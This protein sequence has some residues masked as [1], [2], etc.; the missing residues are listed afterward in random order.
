MIKHYPIILR[1]RSRGYY[2]I[3]GEVLE[4]LPELPKE[5]LLN[6]FIQHTSAG[7]S[8]NENADSTVRNDFESFF[9]Y[10][11][12]ENMPFIIHDMEGPDD[13]PA[14]IKSTL[15]GSSISIPIS[16][17]RL[18]LGTWQGIYLCEFRNFPHRRKLVASIYN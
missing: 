16:S 12:P 4:K 13:M 11:V 9:N 18:M 14:H 15:V 3:T 2:I 1:E 6:L 17:G 8:I 5:G 7:I 10:I